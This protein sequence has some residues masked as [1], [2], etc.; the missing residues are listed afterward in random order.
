MRSLTLIIALCLTA[1][2]CQPKSA[3]SG[4]RV[5]G[6]AFYHMQDTESAI[7]GHRLY[8]NYGAVENGEAAAVG[9]GQ[10]IAAALK[11]Q[12]LQVGWDG[13]WAKRIGLRLDWKRRR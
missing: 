12:G 11:Q 9:M 1:V 5:R 2:G 10:E 3:E 13:T 6:Y 4:R 8:L 7:E